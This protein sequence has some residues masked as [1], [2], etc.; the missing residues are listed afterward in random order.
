MLW[1]ELFR[2]GSGKTVLVITYLRPKIFLEFFHLQ[3]TRDS[4]FFDGGVRPQAFW[5]MLNL[6]SKTFSEFF[7]L[8][9]NVNAEFFTVG[10]MHQLHLVIP[11]LR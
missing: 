10:S 11:N 5:V 2:E 8:Q 7:H 4:E 6:R 1:T 3:N 9:S